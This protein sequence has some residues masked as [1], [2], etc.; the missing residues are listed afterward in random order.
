ITGGQ[1]DDKITGGH[2]DDVLNGGGGNDILVGSG[3]ADRLDG[4]D[5]IDT[6]VLG[7]PWQNSWSSGL[8]LDLTNP[9]TPQ[10]LGNGTTV[11]NIERI[12]F[13]GFGA[14]GSNH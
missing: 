1:L 11:V 13:D 7:W 12:E 9:A 14:G 5:G 2:G 8:T 6:A 10:T 3:G 4:G